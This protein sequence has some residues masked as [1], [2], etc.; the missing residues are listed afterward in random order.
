MVLM[1]GSFALAALALLLLSAS[2][3]ALVRQAVSHPIS[4]IPILI[5]LWSLLVAP[6]QPIPWLTV[7]GITE[8]GEGALLYIGL[9]VITAATWIG[10]HHGYAQRWI[11]VSATIAALILTGLTIG[12]SWGV[13]PYLVPYFYP[14]YIAFLGIF[15]F[16]LWAG[17]GSFRNQKLSFLIGALLGLSLIFV[18]ENRAAKYLMILIIPSVLVAW[19]ARP[20]F[21]QITLFSALRKNWRLIISIAVIFVPVAL[22]LSLVYLSGPEGFL[23]T[24]AL[25]SRY[26]LL[27]V[28]LNLVDHRPETLLI[29]Q[30]WGSFGDHQAAYLPTDS[31]RLLDEGT[32]GLQWEGIWRHHFHSHNQLAEAVI[33]GGLIAAGLVLAYYVAI[34]RSARQNLPRIAAIFALMF[35]AVNAAWFQMPV[36]WVFQP[37]A[38]AA[39]MPRL[40]IYGLENDKTTPNPD[41]SRFHRITAK[42]T[43]T[44][45]VLIMLAQAGVAISIRDT[46]LNIGPLNY[47][48]LTEPG[49]CED[50]YYDYHRGGWH[51]TKILRQYSAFLK[52]H[53]RENPDTTLDDKTARRLQYFYCLIDRYESEGRASIR[54][55]LVGL[56]SYSDIAFELLDR[57]EDPDKVRPLLDQWQSRLL[58]F[59]ERAPTRIDQA[60]PYLLWA[61]N[62]GDDQAMA[63]VLSHIREQDPFNP[64]YLWF[65]GL[66]KLKRDDTTQRG[67]EQLRRALD[68]GILRTLPI[69]EETQQSLRR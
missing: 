16:A 4:L 38:I 35:C 28:L 1:F 50:V 57:F 6:F 59:L 43:P 51:L 33:G 45:L 13:P 8:T 42:I 29:G 30:G 39:L 49:Q 26:Y 66:R 55:Q 53:V 46:A 63:A 23:G 54:L 67:L 3:S 9:G 27:E 14:D 20:W 19:Q 34:F 62:H 31:V 36:L 11:A 64:V 44:A 24:G 18:S 47:P 52:E 48:E 15:L 60:A 41:K 2:Q 17:Q 5:G 69:D 12:R 61:F 22:T 40:E 10:F 58:S 37:L 32:E 25:S 65:D 21:P 56:I 7:F 68:K